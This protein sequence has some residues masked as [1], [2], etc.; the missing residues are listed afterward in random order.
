MRIS[1]WSRAGAEPAAY[2]EQVA[3]GLRPWRVSRLYYLVRSR[4]TAVTC[5]EGGTEAGEAVATV[6]IDISAYVE[7]KL[8]AMRSHRSQCQAFD[9]RLEKKLRELLRYEHFRLAVP[10]PSEEAERE[11]DLFRGL[12]PVPARP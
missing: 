4:S 5:G 7:R 2:A 9:G 6:R 11:D 12:A 8:R 1:L 10:L 3:N